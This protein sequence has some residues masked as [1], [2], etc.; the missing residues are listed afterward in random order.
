MEE[1]DLNKLRVSGKIGPVVAYTS[2]FG[3]LVLRKHVIPTDPKTPKQLAYRM[4]FGLVNSSLTPFSKIIKDGFNR[5]HNAYRSVISLVLREAIVGEYPNFS[6]DYSKIP[7]SDGKLK[8]PEDITASIQ[9][10]SLQISWN[11]EITG[12]LTR[13][14]S[15]NKMNIVCFDESLQKVFIMYNIARRGDGVVNIDINKILE[16]ED[17]SQTINKDDL[18]FWIYLSSMDGK[19]NSGSWYVKV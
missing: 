19:D 14:R 3:K 12:L 13:N 6:I 15:D 1:F 5:K 2:Q 8:L 11:P 10:N 17:S 9:N 16:Q 18:H 4:K 7:L